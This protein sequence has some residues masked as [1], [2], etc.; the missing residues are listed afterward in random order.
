MEI[1]IIFLC[2]SVIVILFDYVDV[3]YKLY[4]YNVGETMMS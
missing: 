4:G 2:N 3:M 1:K